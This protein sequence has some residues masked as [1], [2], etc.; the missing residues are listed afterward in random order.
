VYYR[1]RHIGW[2]FFFNH[3]VIFT[4]CMHA[5]LLLSGS[6]SSSRSYPTW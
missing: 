4:Y 1:H 3:L 6:W 2:S 5:G